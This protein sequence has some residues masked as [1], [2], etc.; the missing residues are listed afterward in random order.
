MP[1]CPT[2]KLVHVA[3]P[4]TGSTSVVRALRNLAERHHGEVTLINEKVDSAFKKRHG[5]KALGARCPGRA[6]HLSAAQ[7]RAVLGERYTEAL[8][9]TFVRSPWARALS[10]Y[11]FTRQDHAPSLAEQERRGTTRKFHDKSFR[12]WLEGRLAQAERKNGINNQLDK[13]TDADGNLIV[14][15]VGRLSDVQ[16]G[17]S[18][19]CRRANLEPIAVPHIN[20]TGGGKRYLQEYDEWSKEAVAQLYRRDIEFFGF[21]FGR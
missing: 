4:K 18:E 8:T 20:G 6:K 15:F 16:N 21:E 13:L 5:L 9:F 14:D 3:I 2:L 10:R 17:F 12:V 19:V 7:L 11:Y 1:Y